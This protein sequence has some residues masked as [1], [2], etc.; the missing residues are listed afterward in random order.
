MQK[1]GRIVSA[2]RL[3][4]ASNCRLRR[5]LAALR[6]DLEQALLALDDAFVDEVFAALGLVVVID[7]F[8]IIHVARALQPLR[9]PLAKIPAAAAAPGCER[10]RIRAARRARELVARLLHDPD[11]RGGK[12]DEY[13][14][15]SIDD[16]LL[17]S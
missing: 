7:S 13:N 4:I 8:D 5:F 16:L 9:R 6:L 14:M 15:T 2:F 12:G 17:A 11:Q 10:E 1:G 3:A